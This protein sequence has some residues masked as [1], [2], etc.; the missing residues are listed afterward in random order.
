MNQHQL[1][2]TSP[3]LLQMMTV[4][5]LVHGQTWAVHQSHT[6]VCKSWLATWTNVGFNSNKDPAIWRCHPQLLSRFSKIRV[7]QAG[8]F[9]FRLCCWGGG[10]GENQ[11]PLSKVVPPCRQL[12][13]AGGLVVPTPPPLY[14]RSNIAVHLVQILLAT[15]HEIGSPK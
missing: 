12:C 10:D 5:L 4:L 1:G 6:R 11:T 8:V 2:S 13:K 15:T 9:M 14:C 7:N 3:Y